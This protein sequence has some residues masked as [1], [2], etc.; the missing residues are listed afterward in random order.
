MTKATDVG[1][2]A[3]HG[4][5]PEPGSQSLVSAGGWAFLLTA[6]F[7]RL[8][9]SMVQLGYLMVLSHDGRGL[10]TG[11]L[12]VAAV[13]LGSAMGAPV[14][15]RLVD[16]LGPLPVVAGAT[17]VSLAGQAAFLI[18]LLHHVASW[19]LLACGA[20][21]GAA[22]PQIGPVARSHWSHLATRLRAPHLV[23]RALGYEGAVDEIGFVI[24][25][26]LASVLVSWLGAA[27]AALAMMGMTLVLQGVFVGHLWREREDWAVHDTAAQGPRAHSR[28]GRSVLW[29][30]LA[31]LGVGI[32]FGATQTA[33]TALFNARGMPGITGLVYGCVG[34]GSGAASLLVG[35]LADRFTV[36]LRVLSGGVLMVL[37]ALGL[38]VLPSAWLVSLVCLVLGVG[39]GVTLVSSF[40]WMERIAP[41]DRVAT[42]MTVLA[43]CLTLGVSAGAAVAGR[44]AVWPA[45]G[46][47]PVLASGVMAAVASAGMRL[48]LRRAA[49]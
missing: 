7:A 27:P 11:G 12:A 41:R 44:L 37:S 39:A 48:S 28:T 33:L 21:V 22:N 17:L 40:G 34:I 16:R 46:F 30:M 4:T 45:H 2:Q 29:P 23:S 9:S 49:R 18:G 43:T 35:R 8:P 10:A 25:P 32:L 3:P 13:G 15:G 14:V 5:F 1:P 38:M 24:G 26:V 20:V 19:Q 31:C 47:W 36:P 42:M 6:F